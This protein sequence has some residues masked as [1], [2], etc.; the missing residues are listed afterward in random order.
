MQASKWKEGTRNT[1][2]LPEAMYLRQRAS[3]I[4]ALSA[5]LQEG[6]FEKIAHQKVTWDY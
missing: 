3:K 5:T 2:E 6:Y 1:H 4:S